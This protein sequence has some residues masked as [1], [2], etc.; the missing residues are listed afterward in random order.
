MVSGIIT[1]LWL[2]WYSVDPQLWL[3]WYSV[4][5]C[6]FRYHRAVISVVQCSSVWFQVSPCCMGEST[7]VF[8]RRFVKLKCA[9]GD[10]R[11]L[12]ISRIKKYFFVSIS[13]RNLVR[14]IHPTTCR[15][16]FS[17][18]NTCA[19]VAGSSED[20]CELAGSLLYTSEKSRAV[21]KKMPCLSEGYELSVA[22]DKNVKKQTAVDSGGGHGVP[23]QHWCQKF[24]E[25][26]VAAKK[27]FQKTMKRRKELGSD[28]DI[29]SFFKK[30]RINWYS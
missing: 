30:P 3:V 18:A 1:V 14:S 11:I 7:S 19:C 24:D 13:F 22:I 12:T 27:L 20:C 26:R 2:V 9:Y 21:R 25:P 10:L 5:P 6:G 23:F 17:E 4:A 16:M 29:R 8:I 28:V 15:S